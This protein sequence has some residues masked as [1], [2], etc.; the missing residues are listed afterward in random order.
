MEIGGF[1]RVSLIDYPGRIASI[2]FVTGCNMRCPFCYNFDLALKNYKKLHIYSEN[3]ILEKLARGR[4]LVDSVEITGGEPTLQPG[5][6]AFM[7]KCKQLGLMVKLDTNGTNPRIVKELITKGLVDYIAIDIKALLE[8]ERYVKAIGVPNEAMADNIKKSIR[9]VIDS[10]I[11]HEFRTTV[12]PGLIDLD[13]LPKMAAEIKGADAYY[14]QQFLPGKNLDPAY[15]NVIPY[16]MN[17]LIIA[18]DTINNMNVVK[19]CEIR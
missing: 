3:E 17:E 9:I 14:L 10:R 1:Q 6:E 18:R 8:Q 15:S 19:K 11:P 5:L 2:V 16:G 12:V 4:N 7:Q 13:D